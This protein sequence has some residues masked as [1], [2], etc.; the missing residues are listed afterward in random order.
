M[1]RGNRWKH[2]MSESSEWQA[3][4][5]ARDRCTNS[6]CDKFEYYGAKGI[7]FLYKDFI[8]FIND[9]G[10]K[11]D[12][13]FWLDRKDGDKNYEQGNCHWVSRNESSR[14]RSVPR[15]NKSGVRGVSWAKDK[16]KWHTQIRINKKQI[17]LGYFDEFEEAHQTFLTYYQFEYNCLPPEFMV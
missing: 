14:N 12:P 13:T 5:H 9:V 11:H 2:G 16:G 6:S 15:H 17:C 3:Y 8:E 7:K 4:S 10:K 1:K